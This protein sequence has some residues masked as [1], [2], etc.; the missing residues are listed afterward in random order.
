MTQPTAAPGPHVTPE[1]IMQFAFAFAPPLAI[2]SCV[3]FG[4]FD[5]LDSGPKTV[6]EIATVSGASVRGLRS[7]MNMLV[8]L[9]LLAKADEARYTLTPESAAFLVSSKPGFHGGLFRHMTTQLMP[10]WLQMPEIVRTGKP[11]RAVNDEPYGSHFFEQFVESIFPMSYMAANGLGDALEI[12]DSSSPISVLDI[13]AGSGVWGLVLAL[14]SPHVRITA[15]DWPNVLTV[16]RRIAERM[17]L[18]DRLETSPGDLLEADFGT[19]H[20]VATIG[21]IL[22][23]EGEGRSRE[24]LKRTFDALAPG[25]IVS[26]AEFVCNDDRTGPPQ[27]LIFSVNMLV[28]SD[29]GDTYTFPEISEWLQ[30]AGFVDPRLLD[31]PG[32]SPLILATRPD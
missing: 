29:D 15:V 3:R 16:T 7:I 26:I 17:G 5:Q 31:V 13:G 18:A 28:N 10:N 4:V 30:D 9:G 6:D 2:E 32:P 23:S 27:S 25:G 1:R 11:A 24:L 12:A 22:H 21:H 19:G 8:G 20:N 14:K